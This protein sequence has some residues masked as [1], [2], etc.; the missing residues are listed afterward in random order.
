VETIKCED[1]LWLLRCKNDRCRKVFD[2]WGRLRATKPIH[3]THCGK[4]SFYGVAD[5]HRHDPEE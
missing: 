3:C 5:F 2:H 4:I 1:S